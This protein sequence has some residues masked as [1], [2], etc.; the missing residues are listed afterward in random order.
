MSQ[1]T[2]TFN[3]IRFDV[4]T[5]IKGFFEYISTDT[6]GQ[7]GGNFNQYHQPIASLMMMSSDDITNEY[8]DYIHSLSEIND[9]E[10][11]RF[12]NDYTIDKNINEYTMKF[13]SCFQ[14]ILTE[15]EKNQ[16]DDSD[17]RSPEFIFVMNLWMFIWH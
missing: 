2:R 8:I 10:G 6:R 9:R 5:D 16:N 3:T 17:T 4:E 1:H 7:I 15:I 13:K 14:H 11:Y 12:L